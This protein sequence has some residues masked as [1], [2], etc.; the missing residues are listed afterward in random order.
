MPA[1]DAVPDFCPLRPGSRCTLSLLVLLLRANALLS[2]FEQTGL[3]SC[4]LQ[5]IVM[6]EP[7]TN[8]SRGFGFVTFGSSQEADAAING[9]NDQELDGRRIKVNLAN[10]KGAPTGGAPGRSYILT[11]SQSAPHFLARLME[12]ADMAEYTVEGMA[13]V[14]I[15]I[16]VQPLVSSPNSELDSW[17]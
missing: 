17:V 3:D 5:S 14:A 4:F 1:F 9:L 11:A 6:R 10:P 2:P 7:G 15:G 8:K 12:A 16:T 13:E